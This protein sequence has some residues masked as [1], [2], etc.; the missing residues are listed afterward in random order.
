[1]LSPE[2]IEAA[3]DA[4]AAVYNNIEAQMLD[5]LVEGLLNGDALNQQSTTALVLLSQT[6]EA[7]LR[8]IL[9]QNRGAINSATYE[10]VSRA[11]RASDEDDMRRAGGGERLYPQQINATIQGVA[12]ILE[13]DNLKMLQGAK[14][15][16]LDTSIEAITRINTGAMTTERALHAAVRQLERNGVPIITY[17]N[18]KT[19][20]VTVENKIDVAVRRHIRTQIAQ[21]GGRMTMERLERMNIDLVEV[22]SHEDARPSHAAWQ[23]RCYSLRG[24]IEIEGTLYPDFYEATRYGSVDG[25]LG[26]NCR[27]S[28][29]P[30][31]HG[32]PRAYS[33][34][35]AHPS[36]LS[37]DEI[38]E[39][40]QG[41]RA[42]ERDI[43]AAKREMRG[44]QLAYDKFKDLESRANLYKAQE[45]LKEKQAEMRTYIDEANAKAK[46]GTTVLYR[47]PN[48]EWAGDMPKSTTIKGSG[49]KLD[50]FLGGSSVKAQMQAKGVSMSKVRDGISA[51]LKRQGG[52]V[53][54]F[55]ALSAADQRSLFSRILNS[56][57]GTTKASSGAHAATPSRYAK[58]LQGKGIADQH[59][60][61]IA[62][63][64]ASSKS[65]AA[66]KLFE[67]TLADFKLDTGNAGRSQAWYSPSTRGISLNMQATAKGYAYRKDKAPYQT[68]FH[69]YGHYVDD[70]LG[71]F[72]RS[73]YASKK[74]GLGDVAKQEVTDMV[75]AIKK[76]D[77]VKVQ[78]ARDTLTR[79][80]LK[81]YQDTPEKLGGLSDIIHGATGGKACDWGLPAHKKS[82]WKSPNSLATE[83][84]AHFYETTMA[85]PAALETLKLYLPQT[86]NAFMAMLKGA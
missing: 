68:F 28:F 41:Q 16:F 58:G 3:G 18:R 56:L 72:D 82:Y 2:Q 15:T 13:R 36:G 21:D 38:Y 43:R 25:L 24:T 73:G 4:V 53:S 46:K 1:M 54:D 26:A 60:Q 9:E 49:R 65:A 6:H 50:D 7:Q 33:P 5:V 57:N 77:G 81:L 48:R 17:Q 62:Q 74:A 35:P 12:E 34:N 45:R 51:E 80:I 37:G 47:R 20:M 70:Y 78:Q 85:N 14:Q 59:V 27:H 66:R 52:S 44:A 83:T 63:V 69:E 67:D 39:L 61:G 31:R 8:Q 75:N 11:I 23:G 32:A 84:F 64:A 29:G 30:Y 10:A 55:S 42:L 40:E 19:G 76:R 86:Y 79:E 22:S 71:N